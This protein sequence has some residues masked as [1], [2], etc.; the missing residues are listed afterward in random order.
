MINE[1]TKLQEVPPLLLITPTSYIY[2]SLLNAIS[3][4]EPLTF[5][6]SSYSPEPISK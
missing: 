5:M 6:F 3:S 2:I 4:I 1:Y